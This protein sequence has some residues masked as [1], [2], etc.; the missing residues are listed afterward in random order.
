MVADP[1][2]GNKWACFLSRVWFGL[3][4]DVSCCVH[5]GGRT[6]LILGTGTSLTV[7]TSKSSQSGHKVTHI[8]I[9]SVILINPHC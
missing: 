7:A 2:C 8:F 6:K 9:L 3:C 1:L 5:D 4:V